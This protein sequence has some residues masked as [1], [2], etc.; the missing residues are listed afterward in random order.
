MLGAPKEAARP[1]MPDS[2]MAEIDRI[3]GLPLSAIQVLWR[4]YFRKSAPAMAREL[5]VRML[6]WH[7]QE[8]AF[9]GHDAATLRLLDAYRRRNTAKVVLFK[10]LKPG[11]SVVRE[12]EGVRHVVTISEN[13][14]IWQSRTY[15]SLSAIAREITG[16]RW[17][18]PRFFGLRGGER[19]APARRA[20]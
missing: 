17:N 1:V 12:Y 13:G 6:A 2:I 3:S 16:S 19:A 5:L 4:T 18:G 10:R 7:I 15:D 9:G 20:F 14:F 8:E 11:T